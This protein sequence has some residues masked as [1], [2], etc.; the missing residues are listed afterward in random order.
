M[1]TA[2]EIPGLYAKANPAPGVSRLVQNSHSL[3]VSDAVVGSLVIV[4]DPD[5]P[6]ML[7]TRV[8]AGIFVRLNNYRGTLGRTSVLKIEYGP[9]VIVSEDE[10]LAVLNLLREPKLWASQSGA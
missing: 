2:M 8:L 5:D 9:G 7:G 6:P 4:A 10:R 3:P 1:L